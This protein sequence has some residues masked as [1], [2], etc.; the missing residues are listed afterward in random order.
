M[1]EV[2]L[3]V[4][5]PPPVPNNFQCLSENFDSLH[6]RWDARVEHQKE[7]SMF[8]QKMPTSEIYFQPVYN[9]INCG[10]GTYFGCSPHHSERWCDINDT[11]IKLHKLIK[12]H[13]FTCPFTITLDVTNE[14]GKTKTDLDYI[15]RA[16]PRSPLAVLAHSK[17]TNDKTE[18]VLIIVVNIAEDDVQKYYRELSYEVAVKYTKTSIDATNYLLNQ[19]KD[20]SDSAFWE[21]WKLYPEVAFSHRKESEDLEYWEN[22]KIYK[23]QQLQGNI[24]HITNACP[25]TTVAVR[26]R[27]KATH[28]S[29]WAQYDVGYDV[30][31]PL[32]GGYTYSKTV[33]T[34]QVIPPSP[35]IFIFW[36][37]DDAET[38]VFQS[39]PSNKR[40]MIII[41]SM[42]FQLTSNK[43]DS[44]KISGTCLSI[45]RHSNQTCSLSA[46]SI[47]H[48]G[49]SQPSTVAVQ[50]TDIK[51]VEPN[52]KISTFE[53]STAILSFQ[54]KSSTILLT[55][56]LK[57]I[58]VNVFFWKY[59]AISSTLN[60]QNFANIERKSSVITENI[61][62]NL[63]VS[64]NKSENK[65]METMI[66]LRENSTITAR[67]LENQIGFSTCIITRRKIPN[68]KCRFSHSVLSPTLYKVGVSLRFDGIQGNTQM[69]NGAVYFKTKAPSSAPDMLHHKFDSSTELFVSWRGVSLVDS[70]GPITAYHV[71]LFDAMTCGDPAN[72]M[73]MTCSAYCSSPIKMS[74][75]HVTSIANNSTKDRNYLSAE[76][77]KKFSIPQI[78]S[79]KL[80]DLNSSVAYY[81]RISAVNDAGEGPCS[82]QLTILPTEQL[83]LIITAVC[84]VLV[85]VV[86]LT[87][88]KWQWTRIKAIVWPSVSAPQIFIDMAVNS[89]LIQALAPERG[90]TC[91]LMEAKH[92][93]HIQKTHL[94]NENDSAKATADSASFNIPDENE[95]IYIEDDVFDYVSVNDPKIN[96]TNLESTECNGD[97]IYTEDAVVDAPDDERSYITSNEALSMGLALKA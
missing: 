81:V 12:L 63:M 4:G 96:S 94:N 51:I 42:P 6:C 49:V 29:Y 9:D 19:Q 33:K 37:H 76:D 47:N 40:V 24:F 66:V 79:L 88:L 92:M 61:H 28:W 65:E 48:I 83:N 62:N 38:A 30:P 59:E 26:A 32:Y 2:P 46:Q 64:L 89:Q 56:A 52:V 18:V 45:E 67:N 90:E 72:K 13:P 17:Y 86:F 3:N 31:K 34:F 87:V 14:F 95:A 36:L 43:A 44:I 21:E 70:N 60:L 93:I 75:F 11:E 41:M 5:L 84:L 15:G 16:I 68:L 22:A 39:M 25:N 53:N 78:M 10:N 71:Y 35:E 23:Q 1:V 82:A 8:T 57:N 54:V 50:D 20:V 58:E 69:I 55:E 77:I 7:F 85:I 97:Y 80:K 91:D 27:L 73:S 74:T